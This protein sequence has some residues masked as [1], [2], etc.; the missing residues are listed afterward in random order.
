[1][2]LPTAPTPNPMPWRSPFRCFGPLGM[3][4]LRSTLEI[5]TRMHFPPIAI[6]PDEATF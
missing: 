3:T 6:L 4:V 5:S 1:M 2:K